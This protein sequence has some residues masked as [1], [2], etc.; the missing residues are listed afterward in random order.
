[1]VGFNDGH[2]DGGELSTHYLMSRRFIVEVLGGVIAWECYHHSFNDVEMCERAR[3]A[4]RY[5][6]AEGA[7]VYHSHWL[8]G[9]R[10][11]DETDQRNLPLHGESQQVFMDRRAAG[12][13]ND[14]APVI[15]S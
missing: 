5:R 7:R 3:N 13:P 4:A 9:D 12:F 10:P 2:W 11:Q 14:Y 8:F 6:W 1:M 15:R